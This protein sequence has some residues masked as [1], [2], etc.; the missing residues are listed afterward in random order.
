[1]TNL[2][3]GMK[4]CGPGIYVEHGFSTIV[5]DVEIGKNFW[6]NQNVT[7][8]RT[9]RGLPIIGDNVR[10]HAGAIVLGPIV[11]GD[12]ATIAAG[13]VVTRSVPDH[14]V[15]AG[16]PARIIRQNGVRLESPLDT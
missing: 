14:C 2:Y 7:I 15:V 10:I 9:D 5:A 8:G 3:L 16:N 11:I 12:H 6:L 13:S 4:T 1:M